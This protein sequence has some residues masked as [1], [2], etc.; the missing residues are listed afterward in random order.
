MC[1][2]SCGNNDVVISS[3]CGLSREVIRI[4]RNSSCGGVNNGYTITKETGPSS[5]CGSSKS[6][7]QVDDITGRTIIDEI[8]YRREKRRKSR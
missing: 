3:G 2:S 8:N 1:G 5:G 6:S 4:S 7:Y